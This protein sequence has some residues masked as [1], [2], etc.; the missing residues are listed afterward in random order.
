MRQDQTKR[1]F[2]GDEPRG[3]E[4][5]AH[6]P[7][8]SSRLRERLKKKYTSTNNKAMPPTVGFIPVEGTF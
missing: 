3:G 1:P 7:P 4:T 5:K 6:P 2:H 8:V